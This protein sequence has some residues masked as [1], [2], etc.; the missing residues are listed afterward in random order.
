MCCETG[1]NTF[2]WMVTVYQCR[3]KCILTV[4]KFCGSFFHWTLW[5]HIS[6]IRWTLSLR[7]SFYRHKMWISHII[8]VDSTWMVWSIHSWIVTLTKQF[9]TAPHYYTLCFKIYWKKST[10]FHMFWS[11]ILEVVQIIN[12]NYFISK[13]VFAINSSREMQQAVQWLSAL[14]P[15]IITGEAHIICWETLHCK[16]LAHRENW[17]LILLHHSPNSHKYGTVNSWLSICVWIIWFVDMCEL[18]FRP[19]R[20]LLST[21]AVGAGGWFWGCLQKLWSNNTFHFWSFMISIWGQVKRLFQW[22][23]QWTV[24]MLGH[25]Q[26]PLN[27]SEFDYV[28]LCVI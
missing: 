19:F 20:T 22:S 25:F 17:F 1:C 18:C 9:K 5:C 8:I 2:N 6:K 12:L 26:I 21:L 13:N 24:G 11:Q 3:E 7:W 10:E 15:S 16:T 28:V 14:I 27:Y 23:W 4:Q